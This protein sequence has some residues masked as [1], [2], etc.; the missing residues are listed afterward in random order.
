MMYYM[1]TFLNP[2]LRDPN[3]IRVLLRVSLG[4][5]AGIA[6]AWFWSPAFTQSVGVG[7]IT[8]GV[9]TIAFLLGFGIDVFFALL[10]RL[11][12][13]ITAAIGRLGASA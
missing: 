4:S 13:M 1:R 12:T 3:F 9:L 6:V 5:F 7:D 11:V 10:D 8:L 2:L